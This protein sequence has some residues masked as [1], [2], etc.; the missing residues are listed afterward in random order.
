MRNDRSRVKVL[1]LSC[2][3]DEAT[4]EALVRS[5]ARAANLEPA[6]LTLHA[7]G[8]RAPDASI[9]AGIDTAIITGSAHSVFEDV[10]NQDALIETIKAA[11]EKN[12]P[13]LG[14]CYGA[15]LL[16]KMYGGEVVRDNAHAE[17]GTFEVSSSDESFGDIIFADAPF[18]FPV[19][20]AHR[21]RITRLPPNATLLASSARC[22]NQAFVILGADM[23]GMQ[24]HPERDVARYQEILAERG[25]AYAGADATPDQ[26]RATLKETPDAAALVARFI[27]RMVVQRK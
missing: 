11:R 23:Y 5:F 8:L 26:I 7:V 22:E 21:D 3:D 20:Q 12:I 15:Q 2:N 24:F 25:A 18:T 19:M 16:A 4:N 27:D 9:L 6:Q 17:W 14:V 13:V 1:L 10:P